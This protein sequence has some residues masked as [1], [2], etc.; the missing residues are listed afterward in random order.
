MDLFDKCYNFTEAKIAI[1]AGYYPYFL[2]LTGNEGTEAVFKGKRLIMCGSNNYLGLTVDPRVRQAAIEAIEKFGS[3]CT[4]SRFLNGNLEFH[5]QLER[6]LAAYVGKEAALVFSTGMQ[7]NLGTISA[8]IGRG[9]YVILDKEDHASIVDGAI[10]S[11]GEIRRYAHNDMGELERLLS[12]LPTD[13]GKLVVVDGVFSMG[14]DLAPLPEIVALCKEYDA[15][16]MVD[17]A[18]G[19]GVTGGGRGTSWQMG[20]TEDVDLIM[21]TF[22]KSFASLGGFIAGDEP[23]IHYIK[24][25]ARSLLF[26]ASIPPSSGR[27]RA[28]R[29]EDHARGAGTR[30]AVE[31]DRRLY[32]RG[33]QAAGLQHR[34]FGHADHPD[35][36]RRP[37]AHAD[38][39]ARAVR[40]GRVRQSR[41]DARRAAGHG[42][43]AHQLYGDSHQRSVGQG[44]GDLRAGGETGGVDLA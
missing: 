10:L 26:S 24:H 3:S 18:H 37:D 5:E 28:G 35:H 39:L 1:A 43:A 17:D 41:A 11:M 25:H 30:P 21:S 27:G 7:V 16:L 8:L 32:A 23:V 13:K 29:A 40:R 6:E 31:R 33:L 9:D 34:Q 36:H 44:A 15:R 12:K 42:S 22:S 38:D 20:V 4:G 14:G 19:L 2:P